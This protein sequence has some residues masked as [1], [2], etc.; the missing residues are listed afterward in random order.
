MTEGETQSSAMQ[1]DR[2][3][4]AHSNTGLGMKDDDL[5]KIGANVPST[6]VTYAESHVSSKPTLEP[7]LRLTRMTNTEPIRSPR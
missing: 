1:G 3:R 2:R 5:R 7:R 6:E 4:Y